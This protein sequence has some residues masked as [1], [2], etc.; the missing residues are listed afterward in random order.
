LRL[1]P[2]ALRYLARRSSLAEAAALVV[3][4]RM[5]VTGKADF[6]EIMIFVKIP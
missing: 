4:K 1:A 5:G 6:F 3:L 2:C